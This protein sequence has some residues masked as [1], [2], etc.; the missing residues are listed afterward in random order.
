[1]VVS[2]RFALAPSSTVATLSTLSRYN[3]RYNS[4]LL[5]IA[6]CLKDDTAESIKMYANIEG[7]DTRSMVALFLLTSVM[8]P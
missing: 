5:Y 6:E 3:Y 4:I 1:M 2:A 7:H 8:M